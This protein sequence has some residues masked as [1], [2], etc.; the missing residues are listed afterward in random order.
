MEAQEYTWGVPAPQWSKKKKKNWKRC[1]S[2]RNLKKGKKNSFTLLHHPSSKAAQLRAKRLLGPQFLLWESKL[3]L[4]SPHLC[5]ML[6]KRPLCLFRQE[7]RGNLHNWIQSEPARSWEEVAQGLQ[8]WGISTASHRS[9]YLA[10]L[11]HES[12][13]QTIW[14]LLKKIKNRTTTWSSGPTTKYLSKGIKIRIWKRCLHSQVHWSV[15]Y[16]SQG[17]EPKDPDAGKDWGQ[18]EKGMAED[19]MVGW[20][21][22]MDMS[23]SKVQELV[24]DL[25]AWL[26]AVHGVTKSQT[27]FRD[28]ITTKV[29][30]QPDCPL[31]DEWIKKMWCICTMQYHAAFKKKET[32]PFVTPWMDLELSILSKISQTQKDK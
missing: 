29:C 11:H 7:H 9:C 5:R 21:H 13:S 30:R 6:P 15:I 22:L 26:A 4:C 10:S 2:Q 18:E 27:W 32:L 1:L 16:N 3:S 28:W 23:L 31:M 8:H 24:L 20:H 25:E 12:C 19:E 14:R 17:V